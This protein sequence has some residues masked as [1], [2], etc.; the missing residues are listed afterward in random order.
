MHRV[1]FFRLEDRREL[2]ERGLAE[3]VMTKHC[4]AAGLLML[5]WIASA[6]DAPTLEHG[7][8]V[9]E[10]WCAPCHAAGNE[11]PGTAALGA[12]YEG[13][14]PAALAERADLPADFVKATVRAGITVMPFFRKTEIG[15]ADLDALAAYLSEPKN[16]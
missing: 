4:W 8:A 2:V 13:K 14:L 6:A 16:L 7:K 5:P 3:T 12:K 11:H 10:K 15:D 9:F 1:A